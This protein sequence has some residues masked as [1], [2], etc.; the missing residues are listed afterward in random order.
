MVIQEV[1]W[2]G[3]EVN[4]ERYRMKAAPI[5]VMEQGFKMKPLR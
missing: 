2:G 4:R 3:S 5:N 1:E